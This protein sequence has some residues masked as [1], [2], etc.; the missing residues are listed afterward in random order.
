MSLWQLDDPLNPA[1]SGRRSPPQWLGLSSA[2]ARS[3]APQSKGTHFEPK[4]LIQGEHGPVLG[5]GPEI[6]YGLEIHDSLVNAFGP[7][8]PRKHRSVASSGCNGHLCLPGRQLSSMPYYTRP[9]HPRRV[10]AYVV[11]HDT[12]PNPQSRHGETLNILRHRHEPSIGWKQSRHSI[13]RGSNQ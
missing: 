10:P 1:D 3:T 9:E 6:K 2:M 4:A 12:T 5:L 13:K 11:A 7:T 8:S